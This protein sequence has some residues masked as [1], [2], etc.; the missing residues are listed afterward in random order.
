MDDQKKIEATEDRAERKPYEK[1]AF[2][3]EEIFE[4]MA[5]TCGKLPSGGGDCHGSGGHSS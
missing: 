3:R 5:L 2:E 1:P 4:T